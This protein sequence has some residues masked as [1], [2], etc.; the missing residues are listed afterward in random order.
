[1]SNECKFAEGQSV[2]YTGV[3]NKTKVGKFIRYYKL[4]DSAVVRVDV[5]TMK[6]PKEKNITVSIDRVTAN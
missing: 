6:S 1:M 5:G 2:K 3:D 4:T